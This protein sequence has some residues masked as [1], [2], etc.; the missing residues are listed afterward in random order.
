M[1]IKSLIQQ[2]FTLW[3]KTM[4]LSFT[5]LSYKPSVIGLSTCLTNP[6]SMVYILVLQTQCRQWFTDL[7][8]KSSVTGLPSCLTNPVTLVCLLVLQ[9][10]C[11]WFT[12][13]SYIPSVTGFTYLSYKPSIIGSIPRFSNLPAETLN[14]SQW[15]VVYLLV[16]QTQCHWFYPTL[17]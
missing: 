11:H 3:Y 14:L 10:Q 12:Y 8:Y 7:S 9:T 2:N 16:L 17:F 15:P 13:L 4:M 6:V 1:Y 5:Y